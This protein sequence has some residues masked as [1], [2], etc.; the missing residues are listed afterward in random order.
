MKLSLLT[1]Q[2]LFMEIAYVCNEWFNCS[3]LQKSNITAVCN[4]PEA[5]GVREEGVDNS[6]SAVVVSNLCCGLQLYLTS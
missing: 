6:H 1:V 3:V 4:L 2:L 5:V